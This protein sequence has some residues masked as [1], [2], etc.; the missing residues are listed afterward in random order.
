M[1]ARVDVSESQ[2]G[3]VPHPESTVYYFHMS[4]DI[5]GFNLEVQQNNLSKVLDA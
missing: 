3:W 4:F 1:V 2:H 5:R